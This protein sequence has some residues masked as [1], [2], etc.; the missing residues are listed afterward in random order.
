MK[1]EKNE[2]A[3]IKNRT[4]DEIG[5]VFKWRGLFFRGIFPQ[6][7]GLVREFF[8]SGFVEE[9]VRNRLFPDSKISEHTCEGYAFLVEH[10]CIWPVVYPYE[11]TFSMLQDATLA[12]LKVAKIASRYSYN[13]KDCHGF[14]VLFENSVPKY[15][16]LGTFT[17]NKPGCTGWAPFPEFMQRYYC[18]LFYWKDSLEG[19]AKL[20]TIP[21][22]APS[23]A[24]YF[25]YR[26]RFLRRL[27][28][29][30]LEALVKLSF[31]PQRLATADDESIYKKTAAMNCV[32]RLAVMMAKK[33]VNILKP[34]INQNLDRLERRILSMKRKNTNTLWRNYQANIL[35]KKDRFDEIIKFVNHFCPD[36]KTAIDIAGNQGLFSNKVLKETKIKHIICQDLD[37]Q[38]ADIGYRASKTSDM[39]I[40]F[41]NYNIMAPIVR[42]PHTL[43]C[44]R[45]QSDI[46]FALALLHHLI[47]AQGFALSNILVELERY[48]RNYICIEFM[49]NGL[50]VHGAEVKI[51]DWYTVDWFRE[52]FIRHFELLHEAKIADNAIVF[53]GRKK[54]AE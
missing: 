53:I 13:M 1:I 3:Y 20:S 31:L 32:L 23:N 11:W 34:A 24:E 42:P 39:E 12:V 19:F 46:I 54:L 38:A 21:L 28:G 48:T 18:P 7:E 43:P 30:V 15:I 47:L 22:N 33:A 37:E 9:L 10:H 35:K 44:K 4:R 16:D 26:Y 36:A 14:N 2:I 6:A 5:E 50:W 52:E 51:P 17:K 41:V 25:I 40:S 49:P 27:N 45:F 29:A 8:E